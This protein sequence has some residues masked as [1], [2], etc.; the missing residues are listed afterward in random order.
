MTRKK[1]FDILPPKKFTKKKTKKSHL[2][3]ARIFKKSLI[4]LFLL[5]VLLGIGGYFTLAKVEIE[6][7]PETETIKFERKVI[8]SVKDFK[9]DA[10]EGTIPA[11]IFEIEK[12]APQEFPSSGKIEKQ[13]E[14][15]IRVYNNYYQLVTL[16]AGTRFQP[17]W[18][19][20]LYFC[21]LDRI[22]IPAKSYVDVEVYS[23]DLEGKPVGGE[24]YNI[25]PSKFSVPGL[26]GGDLFFYIHGES[27]RSMI[28][29]GTISQVT[30]KDLEL[31]KE[32]LT[33]QLFQR[34]NQ[35]LQETLRTEALRL[36]RP[37]DDFVLLEEGIKKEVL[38][39]TPKVEI[40]AEVPSFNLIAKVNYM[41]LVFQKSDLKTFAEQFI[42]ARIPEDKKLQT[43]STKVNFHP[44]SI[45]L[46]KEEIILNL[47][48]SGQ[49]YSDI[50]LTLLMESL[51]GQSLKDSKKILEN[52]T[53]IIRAQ[54]TAW[55][56]WI[57][58]VPIDTEKIE[59]KI[60]TID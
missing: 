32:T 23:C 54:L 39:I 50:N 15:T 24:K 21:S 43:E 30:E 48:F 6:I 8:A 4:F 59:L 28:G 42:T 14:G 56:F 11:R 37:S 29:G 27:S 52:Q 51:K 46:E 10:L 41:A 31:A 35:S 55:P 25:E 57:Q 40:G 33:Q 44:E 13:A 1:V 20:V 17:S 18:E 34:S 2:F 9:V 22:V 58:K 53:N 19:Q 5:F 16:I 60:N 12:T 49:I 36:D 45:D 47:D 26:K 7:W 3:S 38:E